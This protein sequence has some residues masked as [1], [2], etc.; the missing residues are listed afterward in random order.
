MEGGPWIH[1]GDALIVVEYDELTRPSEIK[2]N[3]IG[4]WVRFYDL[5]PVMMNKD[6]GEK[7]G[8]NLGE[9]VRVDTRFSGYLRVRVK[10]P[11]DQALVPSMSIWAKGKGMMAFKLRHEHVSHFCFGCGR[12]GHAKIN[13]EYGTADV[14]GIRFAEELRA[15]P[16]QRQRAVR[17][18]AYATSAARHLNFDA[19]NRNA[20][21]DRKEHDHKVGEKVEQDMM[22]MEQK[23]VTV[24]VH[25]EVAPHQLNQEIITGVE[26]L[27]VQGGNDMESW[28]LGKSVKTL[29]RSIM[30]PLEQI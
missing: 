24:P 15:S 22:E 23:G 19:E 14:L 12:M 29:T 27:H 9:V 20:K 21:P 11:L 3:T 28:R 7:M 26:D 1:K 10:F 2:I 25:S 6:V 16:P 30:S 17:L 8:R 13:C 5:P 18:K 4:L